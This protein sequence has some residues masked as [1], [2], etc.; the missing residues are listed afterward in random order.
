M[1]EITTR[2]EAILA[3]A[4]ISEVIQQ[5]FDEEFV[6]IVAHLGDLYTDTLMIS[7]FYE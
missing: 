7:T 2:N 4:E 1:D 3:A 5:A 6:N